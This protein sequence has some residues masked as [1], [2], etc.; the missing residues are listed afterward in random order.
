MPRAYLSIGSNLGGRAENCI[1]AVARLSHEVKVLNVS[2]VYETEPWGKTDQPAFMNA[3][4]EI[5]TQLTPHELLEMCKQIEEGMGREPGERWGPRVIDLDIL[6]Y[7]DLVIGDED[8]ILPHPHMHERRFVLAPLAE[9]APG[10]RHPVQKKTAAELLED[11]GEG[12]GRVCR[13]GVDSATAGDEKEI[14]DD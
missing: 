12:G 9:I 4:V 3:A 14:P 6:L 5:E 13:V 10:A 8:L 11:L 7:E 2:A 1:V